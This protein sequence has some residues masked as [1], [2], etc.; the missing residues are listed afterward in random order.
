VAGTSEV[1]GAQMSCSRLP[2]QI[3]SLKPNQICLTRKIR[4]PYFLM[5][6]QM[7]QVSSLL[8]STFCIWRQITAEGAILDP[9]W[10]W[11]CERGRWCAHKHWVH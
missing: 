4:S 6:T 11:S 9:H 8:P 1:R 5:F 7:T 3:Y 2:H 10:W